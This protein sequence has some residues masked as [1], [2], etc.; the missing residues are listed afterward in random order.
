MKNFQAVEIPPR[1]RNLPMDPRGYPIPA[2]VLID[3]KGKAHFTIND[4]LKRQHHIRNDLCPICGDKLLRGRWTLGGPASAFLAEGAYIDPPMHFEC[5]RYAVQVCPYL[6]A[7]N[8]SKRIEARTI[9]KGDMKD[10]LL[11]VDDTMIPDRPPLFVGVMHIGQSYTRDQMGL[12]HTI[13]PKRPYRNVEYWSNGIQL[14]EDEGASIV[15]QHLKA[16]E[17]E[18]RERAKKAGVRVF[19]SA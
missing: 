18:Y 11:L 4:Q 16:K 3:D 2:G 8:Y 13:K 12:I 15:R 14:S 9:G 1:M 5:Y 6:A 7:P 19:K 10:H 17:A